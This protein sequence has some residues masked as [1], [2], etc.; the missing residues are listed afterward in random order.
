MVAHTVEAGLR[1]SL[2]AF[3]D[4]RLSYNLG[5]FH[6]VLDD[7]IAFVNSVTLNRAFF[8]NIGQTRRQGVDIGIRYQAPRWNAWLDYAYIDATYRSGF[9]EVRRQQPG[10]RRRRQP[11]DPA[12]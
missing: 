10:S 11:D 9:V 7:D 3:G 5:L 8:T 6:T 1:G 2:P 12:G 4:G